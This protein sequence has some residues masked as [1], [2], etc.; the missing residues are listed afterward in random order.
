MTPEKNKNILFI[1]TGNAC[2]SVMAERLLAKFSEERG[3]GL[4]VRSCGIAAERGF[5]VPAGALRALKARGVESFTHTPQLV[6]RELLAWAD[7]ALGMAEEHVDQTLE[8][9]PEFTQKTHLFVP[10]TGLAAAANVEDPIGQAD[11]IFTDC[12]AKIEAALKA[13]VV[14]LQSHEPQPQSPRS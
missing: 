13:L 7:V 9:F 11:E 4:S 3:L 5:A 8:R 14:K 6:N 10:Y 1:C 12:C 2:R